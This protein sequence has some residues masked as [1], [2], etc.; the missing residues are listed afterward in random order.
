MLILILKVGMGG[1]TFAFNASALFIFLASVSSP[2]SS[3]VASDNT[4]ILNFTMR[5][6]PEEAAAA[7]GSQP[8]RPCCINCEAKSFVLSYI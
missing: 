5:D 8:K 4:V 2:S 7:K 1:L 6:H 3:S